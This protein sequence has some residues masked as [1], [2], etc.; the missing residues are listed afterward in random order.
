MFVKINIYFF[1]LISSKNK[2]LNYN[3]LEEEKKN[4]LKLCVFCKF[5]FN[6]GRI[7]YIYLVISFK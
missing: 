3:K 7:E 1:I 5:T 4:H 6:L 2:C